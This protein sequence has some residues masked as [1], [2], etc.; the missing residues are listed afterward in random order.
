MT[1]RKQGWVYLTE[2]LLKITRKPPRCG[3][4]AQISPTPDRVQS[5]LSAAV[6]RE[7]TRKKQLL[8]AHK[9]S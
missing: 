3:Y 6:P 1:R 5:Y 7:V 4:L 9:K 8:Y 2:M